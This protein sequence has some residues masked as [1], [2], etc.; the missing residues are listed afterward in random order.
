MALELSMAAPT[1]T[2]SATAPAAAAATTSTT[3]AAAATAA[4]AAAGA[5]DS[6]FL[7]SAFVSQ[8]LE[9]VDVDQNDPLFQAA[10]AQI[11]QAGAKGDEKSGEG[12]EEDKNNRKRKGDDGA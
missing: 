7:D 2:A 6:N 1:S 10:L 4:T 9:S 3:P 11:N 12:A 5:S 8:L